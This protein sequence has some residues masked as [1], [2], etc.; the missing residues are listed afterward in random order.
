MKKFMNE[1]NIPKYLYLPKPY[2]QHMSKEKQ[3]HRDGDGDE[4]DC[5]ITALYTGIS[6]RSD[7]VL[8]KKP[9]TGRVRWSTGAQDSSV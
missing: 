5:D 3:K 6:R 2:I 7:S 9:L 8:T 4:Y 1:T